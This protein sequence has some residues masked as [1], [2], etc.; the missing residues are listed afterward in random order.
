MAGVEDSERHCFGTL[1]SDGVEPHPCDRPAVWRGTL[2]VTEG[3]RT[4]DV[5]ACERHS[6]RLVDRHHLIESEWAD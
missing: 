5:E 6:M 1:V 2:M 4:F 3:G